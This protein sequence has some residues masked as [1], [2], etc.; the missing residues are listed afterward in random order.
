MLPLRFC[1]QTAPK[2]PENRAAIVAIA[3]RYCHN[4]SAG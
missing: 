1:M 2:D 4:Y 3:V